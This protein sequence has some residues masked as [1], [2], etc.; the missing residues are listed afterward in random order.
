M[1]L[2]DEFIFLLREIA[3]LEIGPKVVYPPEP[4]TLPTTKQTYKIYTCFFKKKKEK[5]IYNII[6]NASAM[7]SN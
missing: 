1:Q 3:T 5:R 4:A 6:I 2:D 7:E